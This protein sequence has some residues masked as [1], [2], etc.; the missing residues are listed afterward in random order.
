MS[1]VFNPSPAQNR[2]PVWQRVAII[3]VIVLLLSGSLAAACGWLILNGYLW[4]NMPTFSRYPVQGLDISAHQGEINWKSVATEPWSFVYIKATEGGD[5]K[6]P[7]FA[8]NWEQS[9]RVGLRRGAYHF[10]TFCRP[11]LDQARNFIQSVPHESDSLP[12]VVDLEFGGNCSKRP[13]TQQL[14]AEVQPFL[15]ALEK[16]YGK[17]PVVYATDTFAKTHLAK[18]ELSNYPLWYRDILR[19][20]REIVGR[21]WL[22]WQFSNRRR[23]EG[24]TGFVDANVFAGSPSQFNAWLGQG[25]VKKSFQLED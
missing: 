24:I 14:L 2:R 13:S 4:F 6:D 5:F 21:S 10:F 8:R 7:A 19:E 18:R 25:L 15:D 1:A 23:V 22:F 12:P 9:R 20:P 16:H 3:V 11:G 17:K